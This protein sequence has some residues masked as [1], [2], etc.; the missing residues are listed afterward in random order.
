MKNTKRKIIFECY[1]G[2][3]LHGTNRPDSDNDFMG[4][5][6]PSTEDLLS[7]N[8]CPSEWSVNN[9]VS[10]GPRNNELDVDKKYYSLQRF[11]KLVGDGQ[12]TQLE[13]LYAPD[14]KIITSTPEWNK[15]SNNKEMFISDKSIQPFVG[16]ALAQSYKAEI[17]GS[18]LVLIR[19]VI[20]QLK[21]ENQYKKLED[22]KF[23]D[24]V[25]VITSEGGLPA[26]KIAGRVFEFTQQVRNVLRKLEGLESRYGTRSE[27]A[28]ENGYDWK[29]LS[30]AYRLIFQAKTLKTEG[31]LTFPLPKEQI[32]VIMSIK[33]G[34][35]IA[36]FNTEIQDMLTDLK[37]TPSIL[38]EDV[39]WSWINNLCQ[40]MLYE[41]LGVK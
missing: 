30:H 24:N 9:K 17:K 26:I 15:I 25:E 23:V 29:S 35:Y 33:S 3:H 8:N 34:K 20:K 14:N 6:L 40:E 32:D 36:D 13:M 10:T 39:N 2:S 19:N 7:L 11:L 27:V 5:F 12:S 18:N 28:A 21:T 1:V 41:H 4:V 16:F 31:K 37:N 38:K 22:I